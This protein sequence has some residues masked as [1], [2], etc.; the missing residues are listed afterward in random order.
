MIT[1]FSITDLGVIPQAH[2]NLS[3][4]FTVITGETGAGKTM[5]LSGLALL[6]GR[7]AR[8]EIVRTGSERATAEGR[9]LLPA[10]S[11]ALARAQ[12][13]GA[14]LDDDGSLLISRTVWAGKDGAPGRSRAYL[15]GRSVPQSV[16][17]EVA[18]ELV[19]VHGQSDQ[20]RLRSA[21]AQLAALDEY[22]GPEHADNLANHRELWQA[23]QQL[24]EKIADLQSASVELQR[25][26]ELLQNGLDRIAAAEPK[27][28]ED[29][30]LR[31]EAE[32]LSSVSELRQAVGGAHAVLDGTD[33][34]AGGVAELLGAALRELERVTEADPA[35]GELVARL[36]D[37]SYQAGDISGEL[38]SYLHGLAEDPQRLDLV[39]S[40]IAELTALKKLYGP[41]LAEV[42]N[43]EVQASNRL[44]ELDMSPERLQALQDQLSALDEQLAASAAALTAA[45]KSRRRT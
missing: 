37:L 29:E 18:D 25:E 8:P 31:L 2:L 14:D 42:A 34:G 3:P 33:D 38:S 44:L 16:L 4:G 13:A 5:V 1:E 27:P 19:T 41:T 39:Q 20:L 9:I 32:R 28:G 40:R 7:K 21:A 22:A 35:L 30:E 11:A 17:G 24:A 43:W 36:R 26:A 45:R 6:L 23:R 12:E 15:G 10:G